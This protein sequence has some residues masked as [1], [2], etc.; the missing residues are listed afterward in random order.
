MCVIRYNRDQLLDLSA[1]RRNYILPNKETF[2]NLKK[3]NLLK[4]RGA[5]G[6]REQ[7]IRVWDTI[8]GVKSNN[9]KILPCQIPT[10]QRPQN[11]KSMKDMNVENTSYLKQ[12]HVNSYNLTYPKICN[13]IN[14]QPNEKVSCLT[15]NCHSVQ[16]KDVLIGQMLR[17]DK[18]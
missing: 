4:Y 5:R 2:T 16:Y 15:L 11:I 6:G 12:L 10:V 17:D 18:N 1:V 14:T 7:E 3:Y 8:S 9:L 13:S